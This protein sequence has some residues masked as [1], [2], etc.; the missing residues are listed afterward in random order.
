MRW[1]GFSPPK[2]SIVILI[3]APPSKALHLTSLFSPGC[4]DFPFS[5]SSGRTMNSEQ[6]ICK[7]NEFTNRQRKND[8][9]RQCL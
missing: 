8:K 1:N 2:A 3:E 5:L 7:K 9:I 4:T 6:V